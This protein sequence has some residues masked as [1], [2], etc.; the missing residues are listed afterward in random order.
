MVFMEC[1]VM[2]VLRRTCLGVL[3]STCAAVCQIPER[4]DG[5]RGE[6][7]LA[8]YSG[9]FCG[10][11]STGWKDLI[12]LTAEHG[13]NTID[14]KLHPANFDMADPNYAAFVKDV[15]DTA[16][17]AGLSFY[18]YLYSISRGQR[19]P[20]KPTGAPFTAPDGTSDGTSFCM[21]QADTWFPQFERVFWFAEQ[22]KTL[23]ITGAKMDIELLLARTPC[24]CDVCFGSFVEAQDAGRANIPAAERW[25]WIA[26][27]G[28]PALYSQHLEGRLDEVAKAFAERAH[29]INPR[30][31]LGIM[32][33]ADDLLRR[34]WARH[35]ATAQAPAIMDAWPMYNGLGVT[36]GV[37]NQ[38]ELA[39]DLNPHNLYVPWF[40]INKYRPADMGEH[41]FQAAIR[42]DGYNMWVLNMIHPSVA[43]KRPRAG[44]A[45]PNDFRDP[46]AYWNA[47][48]EANQRVDL[49]A[50]DRTSPG[51]LP[52]VELMD[53]VIDM[54][55]IGVPALR[56]ARSTASPLLVPPKGTG[57]RGNNTAYIAIPDSSV[58][59]RATIRHLAAKQRPTNLAYALIA[60]NGA[61]IAEGQVAPGATVEIEAKARR[62]GTYALVVQTTVG[63][64]PWY[65]VKVHS[66][67]FGIDVRRKA[68]FF[69]SLPRQY[70]FVPADTQSF[71]IVGA[72]GGRH[73]Q[74]QVR[75]WNGSDELVLDEVVSSADSARKA[76]EILVPDGGGGCPWSFHVGKPGKMPA[77]FYSENY[78]VTVKG[79][80]PYASDRPN[81]VL[82][83]AY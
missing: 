67:P 63:G 60:A 32:P 6:P 9:A 42:T 10:G 37:L 79:I 72:T 69:R 36:E 68:Y 21:Y 15:A 28:G 77:Q 64:G 23:P 78:W 82:T 2:T 11:D 24:V 27:H 35:L 74:M 8:G 33:F 62:P 12:R 1:P 46:M 38:Q 50:E 71:E 25:Q 47:L 29:A 57:L 7:I 31:R 39:K 83:P 13:L 40:R 52:R 18:V 5:P 54:D 41:A 58:P 59:V 16:H 26:E 55:K 3:M 81:A 22:S 53:I 45:L 44:Y 70:V 43:G 48:A 73:Q 4:A 20:E 34:P 19:K 49:W 30:F 14:L 61:P 76:F 51:P 17:D 66:H 75:V 65:S 80:P 56:A